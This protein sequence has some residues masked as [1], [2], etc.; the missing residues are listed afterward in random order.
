MPEVQV[1]ADTHRA[2]C[3]VGE[4]KGLLVRPACVAMILFGS[5]TSSLGSG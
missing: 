2:A 5:P 1:C 4:R 3:D